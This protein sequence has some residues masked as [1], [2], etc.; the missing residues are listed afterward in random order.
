MTV[1]DP[2][3]KVNLKEQILKDQN[4]I[5]PE[6]LVVTSPTKESFISRTTSGLNRTDSQSCDNNSSFLATSTENAIQTADSHNLI[7]TNSSTSSNISSVNNSQSNILDPHLIQADPTSQQQLQQEANLITD[8]FNKLAV[9]SLAYNDQRR[10]AVELEKNTSK[11]KTTF[12][13]LFFII[14]AK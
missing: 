5:Y 8:S 4:K 14:Q 1:L 6:L 13:Y 9:Q 3:F 7:S 10:K 12:V 11:K 2:E